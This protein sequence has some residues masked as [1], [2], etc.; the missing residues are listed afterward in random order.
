MKIRLNFKALQHNQPKEFILL[1]LVFIG[2]NLSLIVYPLHEK[3][4]RRFP[5]HLFKITISIF[6]HKKAINSKP[7]QF[8][9]TNL[10]RYTTPSWSFSHMMMVVLQTAWIYCSAIDILGTHSKYP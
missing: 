7:A 5:F 3:Y 8:T 9:S 10:I 6:L 2:K 1:F 4:T